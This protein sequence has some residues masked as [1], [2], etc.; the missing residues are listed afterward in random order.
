VLSSGFP[1]E[2]RAGGRIDR[3]AVDERMRQVLASAAPHAAFTRVAWIGGRAP[4]LAS[5]LRVLGELQY[6]GPV[7]VCEWAARL[8][9]GVAPNV[10]TAGAHE[11]AGADIVL[12][13]FGCDIDH[14][15]HAAGAPIDERQA[16][17]VHALAQREFLALLPG[18]SESH[19]LSTRPIICI[20]GPSVPDD[21]LVL[22]PLRAVAAGAPRMA[23]GFV[24]PSSRK[25]PVVAYEP[26]DPGLLLSGNLIAAMATGECGRRTAAGIASL[27]GRRGVVL[28]G[29]HQTF[30]H[31]EYRVDVHITPRSP[32]TLAALAR[33]VILE[34]AAG[35]ER[36]VTA[37]STFF[38]RGTLSAT[39]CV[40][41]QAG[42]Q[43]IYIRVLCGR[44]VDFVVSSVRFTRLGDV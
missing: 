29:P 11:I 18:D 23:Y 41:E 28:H 33:P 30:P 21:R 13:D 25:K 38:L 1:S 39:F 12:V 3:F 10:V 42:P 36:L 24:R 6:D 34:V 8:L 40:S 5:L 4:M 22:E 7:L 43:N 20:D 15:G 26:F 35:R 14:A 2:L 44:W 17:A 32:L 19:V 37:R 31:G 27:V 9:C 16:R